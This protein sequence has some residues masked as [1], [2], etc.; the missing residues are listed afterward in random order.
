MKHM[1]DRYGTITLCQQS[2]PGGCSVL[3]FSRCNAWVC[4][5]YKERMLAL[6]D[7]EHVESSERILWCPAPQERTAAPTTCEG[8]ARSRHIFWGPSRIK[9]HAIHKVSCQQLLTMLLLVMHAAHRAS[10]I[11]THLTTAAV[12]GGSRKSKLR[13]S[14]MPKAFSCTS[15]Q[16]VEVKKCHSFSLPSLHTQPVEES[17]SAAHGTKR[18]TTCRQSHPPWQ[19]PLTCSTVLARLERSSSGGVLV[20][21]C[22][23]AVSG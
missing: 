1:W 10:C 3:S 13:G 19:A 8:V 21:S 20:G 15:T 9:R 16:K 14:V 17:P 23:K 22:R 7:Q 12:G 2:Q 11:L 4:R 5:P 6:T 18:K